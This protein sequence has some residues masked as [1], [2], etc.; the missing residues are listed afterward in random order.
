[1]IHQEIALA[2]KRN[3]SLYIHSAYVSLMSTSRSRWPMR[4]PLQ[5]LTVLTAQ[6]VLARDLNLCEKAMTACFQGQVTFR[7]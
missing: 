7:P 1:M 2:L 6:M 5:K 4:R 3:L